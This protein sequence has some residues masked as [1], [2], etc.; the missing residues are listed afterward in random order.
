M[1]EVNSYLDAEF[2]EELKNVL[3]LPKYG[4]NVFANYDSDYFL[5]IWI[6]PDSIIYKAGQDIGE[7]IRPVK[8]MTTYS[9]AAKD[10]IK[11]YIGQAFDI[12]ASKGFDI[13]TSPKNVGGLFYVVAT[14][15][16]LDRILEQYS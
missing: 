16:E 1:S 14:T 5:H 10:R 15:E 3:D 4:P 13:K 6:S 11:Y 2:E 7:D 8:S 9:K 12:L